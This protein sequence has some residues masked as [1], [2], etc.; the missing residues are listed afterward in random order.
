MITVIIA[1]VCFFGGYTLSEYLDYKHL[2]SRSNV[3][4]KR[5]WF[6]LVRGRIRLLFGFCP[7]CNSDAPAMYDCNICD[8]KRNYNGRKKSED[9]KYWWNRFIQP[10]LKK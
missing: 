5:S 6:E 2:N 4:V 10:Y 9:R 3:V 1:I 7:D 8:F